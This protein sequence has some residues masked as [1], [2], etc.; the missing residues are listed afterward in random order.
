MLVC[1]QHYYASAETL[2]D[3]MKQSGD[4]KIWITIDPFPE[5]ETEEKD[6][7]NVTISPTKTAYDVCKELAGRMKLSTHQVSLYEVVMNGNL[8]RPLHHD[9]KVF[10]AILKWSHWPE[11]DKK[12]NYLVVTPI[13][14]L[15]DVERVIRNSPAVIPSGKELKFADNKT[16]SFKTYS[17]ELKSGKICIMKKDKNGILTIVREIFLQNTTIYLGCEKKRDFPWSWALTFVENHNKEIVRWVCGSWV[18]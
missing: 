4:L 8:K 1:L 14:I 3:S 18:S 6:Q 15:K 5:K 17:L 11:D 16:K 13:E 2:G 9:E 12:N 10:D 7:V